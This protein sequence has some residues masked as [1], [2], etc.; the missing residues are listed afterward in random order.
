MQK[1]YRRFQPLKNFQRIVKFG[2]LSWKFLA[3][4]L[5][6]EMFTKI[7]F[8]CSGKSWKSTGIL[9]LSGYMN[10]GVMFGLIS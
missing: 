4:F 5:Y 7:A 6:N 9:I 2:K 1:Q 3:K 10:P 8:R